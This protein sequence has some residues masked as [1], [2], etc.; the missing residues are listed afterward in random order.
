[1]AFD[2]SQISQYQQYIN[3]NYGGGYD[4]NGQWNAS[5][6]PLID[7]SGQFNFNPNNPLVNDQILGKAQQMGF[8]PDQLSQ[9]LG[10]TTA[11]GI[12]NYA[13]QGGNNEFSGI[14]SQIDNA[15]QQHGIVNAD[16]SLN[17]GGTSGTG[18]G[19]TG[20]GGTGGAGGGAGGSGSGWNFNG[21]GGIGSPGSS[22]QYLPPNQNGGYITPASLTAY[23]RSPALDALNQA[24]QTQFDNNLNQ[25]ILPGIRRGSDM[26]G[27]VGGSR[28]GIAQGL[29]IA[30]SNQGLAA[31]LAGNNYNDYN[32]QMNR[33]LQQYQGDQQFNTAQGNLGLG[34]YN[35]SNNF[36]LGLGGLALG[37]QRNM[38][39]FY[40]SQR[41]GDLAQTALGANLYGAGTQGPWNAL[42]S[43]NGIYNN[44]TGLSS[45]G[46]SNS[47]TSQG[48]GTLGTLGGAGAGAQWWNNNYWGG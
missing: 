25:N 23:T 41:Q 9:I 3:N 28:E 1:M 47:T 30:Q 8:T 45:G 12:Q 20:G 10:G 5:L 46:T 32:A 17:Y 42:N 24:T 19:G 35:G 37:N 16:G 31:A 48:G 29:G 11:Q 13:N 33:N 6:N 14:Y 4:A 43:A 21:I 38:Q 27:G 39:D 44:Y 2:P 22:S 7:S 18:G 15:D 34:Y 26:V 36:N 40:T